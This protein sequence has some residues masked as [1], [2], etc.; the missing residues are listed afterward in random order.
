MSPNEARTRL[1]QFLDER[2]F[3][4]VLR[5]SRE[6]V[7]RREALEDAQA[8]AD[9][10]KR[11]YER[12]ASAEEIHAQFL[13][14]VHTPVKCDRELD[15]LGLPTLPRLRRAFLRLI[16]EL[17]VRPTRLAPLGAGRP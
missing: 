5:A 9:R 16:E 7:D 10:L 17:G 12:Y 15:R 11:R 4:P 6:Q 14:D 8:R 13:R 3:A 1:L 2:A